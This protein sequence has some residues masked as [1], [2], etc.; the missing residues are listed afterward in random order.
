MK[1]LENSAKRGRPDIVHFALMEALSTPLFLSNKMRVYVHTVNDRIIAIADNLRIPKSY[2]RFEG[3]MVNLFRDR[4]VKSDDGTVLMELADGT[5]IDLLKSTNAEK[6]VGLSTTGVKSTAEKVAGNCRG[7]ENCVFVVG[8]FP[9][10]HFAEST[11]RQL[12]PVYS[13]S[14]VGL[15]AH[16]VVARLIYECEKL[17]QEGVNHEGDK[18]RSKVGA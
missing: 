2:F 7:V 14:D 4:R 1:K 16:V 11:T 3:L 9:R 12:G 10:G 5:F 15:E 17:L 6:I 18:E 13:I 8:G